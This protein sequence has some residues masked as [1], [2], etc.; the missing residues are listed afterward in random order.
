MPW[1][2]LC[3]SRLK[4]QHLVKLVGSSELQKWQS[5]IMK[6][7]T[8]SEVWARK[9]ISWAIMMPYASTRLVN[10]F[11]RKLRHLFCLPVLPPVC[12]YATPRYRGI[13]GILA[14]VATWRYLYETVTMWMSA[15]I[16]HRWRCGICTTELKINPVIPFHL[17]QYTSSYTAY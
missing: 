5:Y 10:V 2:W 7:D 16:S 9:V 4:C 15:A 6:C 3:Q 11:P 1:A 17:R 12:C 14:N 8:Y 13:V